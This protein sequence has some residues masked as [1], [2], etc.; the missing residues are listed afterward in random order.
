MQKLKKAAAE[1]KRSALNKNGVNRK[2]AKTKS[3]IGTNS[4]ATIKS[5]RVEPW[6]RPRAIHVTEKATAREIEKALGIKRDT[7]KRVERIMHDLE[8][9]NWRVD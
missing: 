6:P 2:P 3:R 1:T 4:S 8:A 7:I 5:R 9:K